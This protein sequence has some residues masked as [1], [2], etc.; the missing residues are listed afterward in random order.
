MLSQCA[1]LLLQPDAQ[2]LQVLSGEA[3]EAL[4]ICQEDDDE[5]VVNL[6]DRLRF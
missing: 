2:V 1:V 6:K 3:E 5:A 4:R